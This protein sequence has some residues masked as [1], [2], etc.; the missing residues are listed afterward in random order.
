MTCIYGLWGL[1][2]LVLAVPAAVYLL[3]PP[4]PE[5]EEEWIEAGNFREL[6]PE[7]PAEFIFRRNRIDGWKVTS[8][9]ATAW[10]V[11]VSDSEVVA[12]APQC[13]HLGCAYHWNSKKHEFFCPCHASTFSLQGD[14]LTGPAPRPLDRYETKIEGDRVLLGAVRRVEDGRA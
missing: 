4:R 8:E 2:G 1:M 13:P 3:W 12:F 14:V 5:R 9:K 7:A 10:V 6:E 11:K